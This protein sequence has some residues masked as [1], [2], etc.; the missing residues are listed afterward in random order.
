[1]FTTKLTG[2]V[3]QRARGLVSKAKCWVIASLE[4]ANSPSRSTAD[5]RP[6]AVVFLDWDELDLEIPPERTAL[7]DATR[8]DGDAGLLP[9]DTSWTVVVDPDGI[10]SETSFF[11]VVD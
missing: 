4:F 3:S 7:V 10:R 6:G 2:R 9:G 8:I 1:M 11:D 5:L